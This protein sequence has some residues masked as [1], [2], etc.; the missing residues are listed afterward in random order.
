MEDSDCGSSYMGL[1]SDH[2]YSE[3]SSSTTL[4]ETCTNTEFDLKNE[5]CFFKKPVS[6]YFIV[7]EDGQVSP[8]FLGP[9]M[10]ILGCSIMNISTVY[11]NDIHFSSSK[12]SEFLHYSE[13]GV[14]ICIFIAKRTLEMKENLWLIRR[15][16]SNIYGDVLL[17]SKTC[18]SHDIFTCT[19][20]AIEIT[21]ES[22][23]KK[24]LC[25]LD[26]IQNYNDKN[27][28]ENNTASC[29]PYLNYKP[30]EEC[31]LCGKYKVTR[32][33]CSCKRKYY[34][35]IKCQ[36]LDWKTHKESEI[37]RGVFM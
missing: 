8:E 12:M 6:T 37:H 11:S 14:E 25:I 33:N 7:R 4:S 34:C 32:I 21:E 26:K 20:D 23:S 17:T 3:K 10:T 18:G 16:L 2:F 35:G 27:K 30:K 22:L 28:G 31:M 13:C 19:K 1:Y 15:G 24:N 29:I 36:E 9:P 5:N